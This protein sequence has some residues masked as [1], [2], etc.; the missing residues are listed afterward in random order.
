MSR[1]DT[2]LDLARANH[3][4]NATLTAFCPFP[5]DLKR[6]RLAPFHI[7]AA[8]LLYAETGLASP[9]HAGLRDAFVAAGPEAEWRETYKGTDIA[10]DFMDRFGC[11]C[12]IGK[13]GAFASEQMW[14]WV[15][16][17]PARLH[18]PWHHHPGEEMYQVIAGEAEFLRHEGGETL[19]ET[20]R[21]GDTLAH[22]AS[23]PHATET[24]DH[25]MMAYVIWR[26]GFEVKPVL[27]PS[28]LM[29]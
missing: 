7:P 5:K 18:Y 6:Q 28:E 14:A 1:F 22:G 3:E 19:A 12:L 24:Y 17:M 29:A 23:Q 20:L 11:Y 21:A 25:P 9:G 15:V 16:Y 10:Q 2:L 13:G 27:T 8:D 4:A 26:N